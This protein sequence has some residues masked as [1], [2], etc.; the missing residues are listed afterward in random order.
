MD[1]IY[2]YFILALAFSAGALFYFF[3]YKAV[4]QPRTDILFTDALNAMVR[5]DKAKAVNILRQ[6]VKQ[7]SSHVR[8][9]LQLGNIIR[10]ENTEQAIKIHQSLTVR[11]K[12]SAEI[13]VDIHRSL[14]N[15][16]KKIGNYTKAK[17]EAEQILTIEKRNLWSL[18]F[19]IDLAQEDQNWDEAASW[20][21]QL[22]KVT[23]RKNK[24]DEAR[25][26]V[27]RGLDCLK[28]SRL[29]DARLLFEK[30]IKL[31][32]DYGLAYR[33]LGDVYEQ[34]RDL[35]KALENWKIYAKKDFK[36]GKVV[37]GKI[38]SALFDLGQYSEVEKFYRQIL[39]LD[40]TN[41]E[42]I[43]R[44][45]NVLDEKGESVAALNLVESAVFPGV[46]D[47]R[48]D[49]M[50]LKLSL[51]TSTPVELSHQIDNILQKLSK[52]DET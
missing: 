10:D 38:E 34:T 47:V 16:Y 31:S 37:Y 40:P 52:I 46:L 11:P 9:Y 39:D 43:I 23:G 26:D 24:N 49:I 7:D 12:L 2:L 27:Y 51:I 44:L 50:K 30:S 15:D 41:F 33:Y 6:V 21:K 4:K 29:D 18:K 22:K 35:L 32:P 3:S 20:T 19:L 17:R 1:T 36:G 13:K 25:F 48:A 42:A 28:N 14:A 8:A 5:G 45:A